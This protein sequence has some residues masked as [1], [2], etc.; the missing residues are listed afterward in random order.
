[1]GQIALFDRTWAK[2]FGKPSFLATTLSANLAVNI[3]TPP[4]VGNQVHH[5]HRLPSYFSPFSPPPPP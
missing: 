1:M 3:G 4:A 2:T 5:H